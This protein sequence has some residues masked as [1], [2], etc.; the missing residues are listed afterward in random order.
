M[1]HFFQ[2]YAPQSIGGF[3]VVYSCS[4]YISCGPPIVL[5]KPAKTLPADDFSGAWGRGFN[6][7]IIQPLVGTFM[8]VV[9]N[10]F[11]DDVLQMTFPKDEHSV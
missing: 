10:I 4:S 6:H 7:L 11:G 2:P 5:Q 1:T 9:F 8:I 3:S